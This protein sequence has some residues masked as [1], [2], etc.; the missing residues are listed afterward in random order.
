MSTKDTTK[1]AAETAPVPSAKPRGPNNITVSPSKFCCGLQELGNFNYVD[2]P[3]GK[4]M[5]HYHMI[6]GS[7]R[8]QQN[9]KP[10][11]K[12]DV[13]EKMR[14][15]STNSAILAT[16]GA[17]QEYMDPVLQE[18]GFRHVYTFINSGH[19]KTPV[20]VWLYSTTEVKLL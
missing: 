17:G 3:G 13:L 19:A 2:P 20:K 16:T 11:T 9:A 14:Y 15:V 6:G 7:W 18:I 10:S 12:E 4:Q 1:P 8:T 5:T